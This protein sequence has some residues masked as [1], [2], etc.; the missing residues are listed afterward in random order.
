MSRREQQEIRRRIAAEAAR[1]LAGE[2]HLDYA[3]ARRRAARRFPHI[4]AH[5][6]PGNGEIHQALLDYLQLFH[7]KE[8]DAEAARAGLVQRQHRL[9]LQAMQS[10]KQFGPRLAPGRG[11]PQHP[12]RLHLY[13]ETPEEV[14]LHLLHHHIPHR[15][16]EMSVRFS[17]GRREP[18]PL[19]AFEAGDASIELLILT[20][21]DRTDPPLDP[22]TERPNS[23]LSI[24]QLKQLLA[25]AQDAPGDSAPD[26]SGFD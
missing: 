6:L 22:L 16:G 12:I 26:R 21:H 14:I 10:L 3:A 11:G 19:L 4:D 9:A 17:K 5:A 8:V 18:R 25:G 1:I 7:G 2:E 13:A 20:P 23:G 15:D 24:H